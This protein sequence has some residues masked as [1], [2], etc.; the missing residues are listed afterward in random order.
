MEVRGIVTTRIDRV[1][2]H[3]FLTDQVE[4]VVDLRFNRGAFAH[5]ILSDYDCHVL[6]VEALPAL[7]AAGPSLPNLRLVNAAI[8]GVRGP[9]TIH[10]NPTR[11]ASAWL[12]ESGAEQVVVP[13]LTL[14]DLLDECEIDQVDVLKVDIEGAELGM[15]QTASDE[16][17]LRCRQLSVEFHDF[18]DAKL[19]PE[20][21]E[22]V[23]RMTRL[24]YRVLEAL[25]AIGR[26]GS[27]CD[28]TYHSTLSGRQSD[29][30]GCG[31]SGG[32]PVQSPV[33]SCRYAVPD[34]CGVSEEVSRQQPT[35]GFDYIP[36]GSHWLGSMDAFHRASNV[37]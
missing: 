13:G 11:C 3:S 2:G 32:E 37:N 18:L 16:T 8:S 15:F 4:I 19:V 10:V 29:T 25:S 23:D 9:V 14:R 36:A 26:T 5:R 33:E 12:P 17:F 20:V 1:A 27:S 24:G 6:G 7:A 22:V 21:D 28:L 35:A 34:V 30:Y 31:D